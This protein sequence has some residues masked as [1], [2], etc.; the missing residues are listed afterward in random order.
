M[1]DRYLYAPSLGLYVMIVWGGLDIWRGWLAPRPLLSHA[2]IAAAALWVIALA[3]QA[4]DQVSAWRDTETL[5]VRSLG[6]APGAFVLHRN[7]GNEYWGQER[8]EEAIAQY[9]RAVA[10]APG[11][12]PA[13][14]SLIAALIEV[15]DLPAT[16]GALRDLLSEHPEVHRERTRL[17]HLLRISGALDE[18]IAEYSRVAAARPDSATTQRNLGGALLEAGRRDEAIRS[19]ERALVLDPDHADTRAMLDQARGS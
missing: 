5:F 6:A 19:L 18:A 14:D 3:V 17:A 8:P 16:V 10:I 15:G 1:A 12:R 2:L 13:H 11:W 9:R 7:L 4:V